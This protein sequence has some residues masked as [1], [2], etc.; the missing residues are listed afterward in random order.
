MVELDEVEREPPLARGRF[1]YEMDL[2]PL[3][4]TRFLDDSKLK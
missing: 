4:G 3:G 2:T 1:G